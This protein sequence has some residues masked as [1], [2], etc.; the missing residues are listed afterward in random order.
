MRSA[1]RCADYCGRLAFDCR[2]GRG[3]KKFAE[4]VV[5]T[6]ADSSAGT[7]FSL[8]RFHHIVDNSIV[9]RTFREQIA[10]GKPLTVHL[11]PGRRLCQDHGRRSEESEAPG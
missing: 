8:V 10:V 11:A 1:I 7:R 9:E 2:R 5:K 4:A 3:T 6:L